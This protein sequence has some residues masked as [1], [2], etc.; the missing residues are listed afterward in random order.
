MKDGAIEVH[1]QIRKPVFADE[2]QTYLEYQTVTEQFDEIVDGKPQTR[3]VEKKVPVTKEMIV[4]VQKFVC[5]MRVRKVNEDSA[6][7][8]DAAGRP[9]AWADLAPRLAKP[10]LVVVTSSGRALPPAMAAVFKPDTIV[11]GLP[12][13]APQPEFGAPM[14]IEP[15]EGPINQTAP[16]ILPVAP[17]EPAPRAPVP[18]PA[19]RVPQPRPASGVFKPAV[20]Q[21]PADDI[22][23]VEDFPAADEPAVE[24]APAG[25]APS[26]P[27]S[28][29]PSLQLATLAESGGVNLKTVTSFENTSYITM[30]KTDDKGEPTNETQSVPVTQLYE[31][32][33]TTTYPMDLVM[34]VTV[35]GRKVPPSILTRYLKS[36]RAV[37]V[38]AEGPDVDKFW[39]QNM[40]PTTV[41]MSVPAVMQGYGHGVP[42]F[43]PPPAIEEGAPVEAPPPPAAIEALPLRVPPQ[44]P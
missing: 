13:E 23:S 31:T 36:E 1:Y 10:T 24:P 18:A 42:A 44:A 39:L 5:E 12:P 32:S 20:F 6:A 30:M 14:L 8:Y 11:L 3:T 25:D 7:A 34:A 16:T 33:V 26:L 41:V 19:K 4:K 2:R 15:R 22:P 27:T 29:P 28:S 35:D 37:V 9:I 40:K 21:A 38:A 17:P 43:A